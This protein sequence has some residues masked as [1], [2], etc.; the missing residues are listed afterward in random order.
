MTDR[1]LH[2][3][4]PA[5]ASVFTAE[6]VAI[7]VALREAVTRGNRG[8]KFLICSNSQS[9]LRPLEVIN[10]T[11]PLVAV[12]LNWASVAA[13]RGMKIGTNVLGPRPLRKG[14]E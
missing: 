5:A 7:Q 1:Q 6:L 9:A 12:A 13:S 2:G 10:S 3:G 4:L 11:N 8:D 14:G